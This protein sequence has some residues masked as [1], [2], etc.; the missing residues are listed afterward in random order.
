M[1]SESEVVDFNG[2]KLRSCT[3][4]GCNLSHGTFVGA[5]LREANLQRTNLQFSDFS[6][7][8][9]RGADLS[10]ADLEHADLIGANLVGAKLSRANLEW[11]DLSD[12]NIEDTT[13]S[14][15]RVEF[16]TM[17][18]DFDPSEHDVVGDIEDLEEDSSWLH[19]DL[20][21]ED[22]ISE[23]EPGHYRPYQQSQAPSYHRAPHQPHPS[24]RRQPGAGIGCSRALFG[25]AARGLFWILALYIVGTSV[26]FSWAH[27]EI[28][29]CVLK[30]AFF[31]LTYFFSPWAHGQVGV[32]V[33]SVVAY[34]ISTTIGGMRPIDR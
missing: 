16:A 15:A 12:A 1:G 19:D 23:E 9:L 3:F 4:E 31:P 18:I 2:A 6:G 10:G 14:G 22:E 5:D 28:G 29:M 20:E 7:A 33:V 11:S 24:H 21:S 34:I 26:L 8:D 13:F 27:G 25:L 17:P 30:L 32:L